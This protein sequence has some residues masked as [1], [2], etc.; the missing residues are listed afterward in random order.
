MNPTFVPSY[1]QMQAA[2]N[3]IAQQ[4]M[5][6][7]LQY[8]QFIIFCNTRGLNP[9]DQNSFSLFY[10]YMI[11]NMVPPHNPPHNPPPPQPPHFIPPVGGNGSNNSEIYIKN[12]G[13]NE[14]S[15]KPDNIYVNNFIN[16]SQGMISLAFKGG[17]SYNDVILSIPGN[18]SI[19]EMF[20][21]YAQKLGLPPA[22]LNSLQFLYNGS[23]IDTFSNE[24]VYSKLKSG[25][26]ITVFDEREVIGA[27]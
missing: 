13:L 21:R 22:T 26:N 18:I 5:Y 12:T 20:E 2:F 3:T 17:N 23:K 14:I 6:Y 1:Q 9:N 27:A 4:Q 8:N 7:Q 25:I 15:P 11:A 24:P 19:R 10:Q 16:N